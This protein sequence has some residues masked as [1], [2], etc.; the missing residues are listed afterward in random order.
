MRRRVGSV[1]A[2]SSRQLVAEIE[3]RNPLF[4]MD[5][6][7]IRRALAGKGRSDKFPVETDTRRKAILAASEP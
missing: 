4:R 5:C 7:S 3:G 1:S 2:L 6:K